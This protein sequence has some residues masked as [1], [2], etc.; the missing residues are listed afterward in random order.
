VRNLEL[1][2]FAPTYFLFG[3]SFFTLIPVAIEMV[4]FTATHNMCYAQSKLEGIQQALK[5]NIFIKISEI[6]MK[7]LRTILCFSLACLLIGS[8]LF[9][10]TSQ[11]LAYSEQE[12]LASDGAVDDQFGFSVAISGDTAIIGA[13]ADD[14]GSNFGQGSAYI[15]VRSGDSWSEQQKITASDGAEVDFFGYS[16]AISGD[17]AVV[18]APVYNNGQGAAYIFVRSGTTWSQQQKLIAGDGAEHDE[19]GISVA[20]NGDTAVIGADFSSAQGAAYIFV[21]SGTTWSP[22][23]KLIAGDG[24]IYD[25]FGISVAISGD[26]AVIGAFQD[27]VESNSEQGSAHIFVRSGGSWSEQQKITAGDGAAVDYF[28]Y[29]V[30]I[31]GDTAVAGANGDDIGSN[32]NQGSAYIFARSGGF[33]S[34][35]Q[36]LTAGDGAAGDYFGNSVAVSGDT[37]VVGALGSN[38][39]QGSAYV[40][41]RSGTT[42][43]QQQKLT[44]SEGAAGDYFGNSVA[45]NGDTAVIGDYQDAVESN[46]TQG[47]AHVF[48]GLSYS[49]LS[50][51]RTDNP[52][53]VIA[54]TDLTYTITVTNSGPSD[55]TDVL[56]NESVP[57]GTSYS[58]DNTSQGTYS[59]GVWNLGNLARGISADMTLVVK[60]NS[61]A[62]GTIT[63]SASVSGN[64]IDTNPANNLVT[65]NTTVNTRADLS[66][67]KTGDSVAV[68][69]TDFSYILRVNNNGPSDATEVEVT[70]IL[71]A[72][73]T[74][75]KST[76]GKG[77]YNNGTG[78]WTVGSMTSGESASL[79]IVVTASALPNTMITNTAR[80]SGNEIDPVSNNNSASHNTRVVTAVGGEFIGISKS[81]ILA[82]WLVLCLLLPAG[83]VFWLSRRRKKC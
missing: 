4:V 8:G 23:Q 76:P 68:V 28:G 49:D 69:N 73:V 63:N 52:N 53:P 80:V 9:S 65:N 31:S 12:L 6:Y 16:V 7:L 64:E 25:G 22:Q 19:F 18:G 48:E 30:A 13:Y 37:A 34:E 70:D 33:W 20:I 79:N 82:P 47:S 32:S 62:T 46:S 11:A 41:V 36:K 58:S 57:I 42:W 27:G 39:Y 77:T 44:A 29:S 51:T 61:G 10:N 83:G 3:F 38:S 26:T 59:S 15:F 50:I 35:Q 43:A 78:I 14:I 67:A 21:R 56:V 24:A 71:P 75:Y 54:G 2:I 74:Y 81:G 45:I 72:G 66:F 1:N 17:I 40:F 60:V 5:Q 55:A